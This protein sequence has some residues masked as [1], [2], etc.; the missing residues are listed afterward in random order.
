MA[1]VSHFSYSVTLLS[2]NQDIVQP[3]EGKDS[4]TMARKTKSETDDGTSR[5]KDT[6]PPDN[7]DATHAEGAM[8]DIFD[9]A[10][11]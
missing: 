6:A 5:K 1:P 2:N 4:P 9:I 11:D 7:E 8:H 3:I 10:A